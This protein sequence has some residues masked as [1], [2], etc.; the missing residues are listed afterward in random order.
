MQLQ[1]AM[2]ALGSPSAPRVPALGRSTGSA[3]P[4]LLR[5]GQT[6]CLGAGPGLAVGPAL[7]RPCAV[8]QVLP[9]GAAERAA[10]L[11]VH[12]L[13]QADA[14]LRAAVYVSLPG[15]AALGRGGRGSWCVLSHRDRVEAEHS[16]TQHPVTNPAHWPQHEPLSHRPAG[17]GMG[18]GGAA[19]AVGLGSS[20]LWLV[21][22]QVGPEQTW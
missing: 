13:H 19:Q 7:L 15:R 4:V 10:G 3:V 18:R 6:A 21:C 14:V 8:L 5:D 11:G 22:L 12:P 9:Q 20:V 1:P 17:G 16:D 2:G